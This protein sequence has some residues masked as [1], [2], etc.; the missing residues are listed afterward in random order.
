MAARCGTALATPGRAPASPA[1]QSPRHRP[2]AVRRGRAPVSPPRATGNSASAAAAAASAERES[3]T[4]LPA[5]LMPMSIVCIDNALER[6]MEYMTAPDAVLAHAVRVIPPPTPPPAAAPASAA[7]VASPAA[8]AEAVSDTVLLS[9][10]MRWPEA[11]E[12][13][14]KVELFGSWDNWTQARA[15]PPCPAPHCDPGHAPPWR[16]L[17]GG[18]QPAGAHARRNAPS[19]ARCALPAALFVALLRGK[20]RRGR[21]GCKGDADAARPCAHRACAWTAAPRAATRSTSRCSPGHM[22]CAPGGAAAGRLRT[23][24]QPAVA[25]PRC[26]PLLAH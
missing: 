20:A 9:T 22:T 17:R 4:A 2:P 21:G 23:P 10:R 3:E 19:P 8:A 12:D 18:A 11:W 5:V 7:R 16:W 13:D 1:K 6:G 15:A 14:K 26:V 24:R 25:S